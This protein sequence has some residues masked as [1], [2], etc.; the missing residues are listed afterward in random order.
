M[1]GLITKDALVNSGIRIGSS[2]NLIVN[3]I[4]N[5]ICQK[6]SNKV[7]M[8]DG[9]FLARFGVIEDVVIQRFGISISMDL[10]VILIKGPSYSLILVRPWMQELH[11]IH[12]WRI[13]N[14][15]P[16]K[17]F[18]IVYDL[19][20]QQL[21]KCI[22]EKESSINNG[23]QEEA[24]ITIDGSSWDRENKLICMVSKD[25]GEGIEEKGIITLKEKRR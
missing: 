13:M 11:V 16:S 7:D 5:S 9:G 18:N 12:D 6:S 24:S 23:K 20:L 14:L 19:Y 2:S 3:K 4:G 17:V 25:A 10:H 22:K 1:K 21:I 15:S 8:I